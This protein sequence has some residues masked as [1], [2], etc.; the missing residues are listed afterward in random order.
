VAVKLFECGS[1]TLH[2]DA[3]GVGH[4]NYGQG[5]SIVARRQLRVALNEILV[6]AQAGLDALD[7]VEAEWGLK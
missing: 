4:I 3:A 2:V 6:D 5:N 1:V 7:A